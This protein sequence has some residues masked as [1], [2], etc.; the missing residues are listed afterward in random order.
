MKGIGKMDL[1]KNDELKRARIEQERQTADGWKGWLKAVS[2]LTDM[3]L[4]A[5]KARCGA[6]A[7]TLALSLTYEEKE[8]AVEAYFSNGAE[9]QWSYA[10]VMSYR[11]DLRI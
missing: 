4:E 10:G 5:F 7:S 11:S 3:P 2:P 1:V 6:Y 8:K 9:A